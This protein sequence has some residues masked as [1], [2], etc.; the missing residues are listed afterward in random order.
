VAVDINLP[1]PRHNAAAMGAALLGL[2]NFAERLVDHGRAGLPFD[3]EALRG[4]VADTRSA[5]ENTAGM[6]MPVEMEAAILR[7]SIQILD[8][9]MKRA[10]EGRPD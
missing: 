9:L 1:D 4:I 8:Y 7:Q 6:G 5:A 10:V 3:E 2:C